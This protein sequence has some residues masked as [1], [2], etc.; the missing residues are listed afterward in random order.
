MKKFIKFLP[1]LVLASIIINFVAAYA[2]DNSA[3][4]WANVTAF[5]GW[6]VVAIDY[7]QMNQV[8]D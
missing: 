7:Y 4:M 6:L 1:L 2:N 3:A 8:A 5:F